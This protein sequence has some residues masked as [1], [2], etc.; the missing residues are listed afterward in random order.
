MRRASKCCGGD[1][2]GCWGA[3]R[4]GV[5]PLPC[6]SARPRPTPR[7][8]TASFCARASIDTSSIQYESDD[9]MHALF[10]S[11]YGIACCVSAM[12]IGKDMQVRRAGGAGRVR[13]CSGGSA[14]ACLPRPAQ[15]C[16]LLTRPR[17]R[18]RQFFG[19]R[20]NLAKLLL[21]AL[22]S[23]VDEVTG[24][25]VGTRRACC[26]AAGQAAEG[27]A[28]PAAPARLACPTHLTR[29]PWPP[30]QVGPK[31]PPV[32]L[33]DDGSINYESLMTN[34]D[35]ALDWLAELYANTMNVIH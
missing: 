16:P 11:D 4:R 20:A 12:R 21:Y 10:G 2:Q 14:A 25:Q 18:P 31:L 32:A 1:V 35:A 27:P 19:A 5:C 34:Y 26:A 28:R 9:M 17:P 33:N 23:G 30:P 22:N 13:L 3:S 15:P 7:A 6:A 24:K 8:G 29:P